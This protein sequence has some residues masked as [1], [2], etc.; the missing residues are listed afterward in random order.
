MKK[1]TKT[2]NFIHWYL[3]KVPLAVVYLKLTYPKY[4]LT[5]KNI[6]ETVIIAAFYIITAVIVCSLSDSVSKSFG[7]HF[8][9]H[10][11]I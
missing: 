6:S 11:I 9:L 3:E 2:T 8:V 10:F 5:Y 7:P 4:H 1:N